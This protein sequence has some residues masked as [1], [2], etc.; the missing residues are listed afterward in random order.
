MMRGQRLGK[1]RLERRLGEGGFATVYRAYDTIEGV[2]VALKLPH[3]HLI[4]DASLEVFRK[5]V[6][7]NAQLDHPGVLP[8][9]Y[10]GFIDERFVVVYPLGIETLGDRLTRRVALRKALGWIEQMLEA[11]AFA[12]RRR[13]LHL[14]L[15]PD[16][17]I[18]FPGDRLR[19]ADFGLARISHRTVAASGSGTVGYLAPEQALGRP[20]PRS[21]VF[22]LGLILYRVLTGALPEWP[23]D[24]PPPRFER[25]REK[26][27]AETIAVL[28]RSLE[29]DHRRR[30]QDA[31]HMLAGF[32]RSRPRAGSVERRRK[33]LPK[34][35]P[36]A[37]SSSPRWRQVRYREFRRRFGKVL[38]TRHHCP[39]CEGPVSEAMRNCPWCG[40]ARTVH[41][42]ATPLP[43]RC[44]RCRR[45]LKLDWRFCPWC[46]GGAIGEVSSRAYSDRRYV[47]R[48]AHCRS[49]RLMP[50]MS[51]CPTCNRKVTRRWKI[52]GAGG[53]CPRCGWGVVRDHWR[54]CP[55]CARRLARRER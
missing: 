13:I 36:T 33:K 15:K 23:F 9:K 54:V 40:K 8:I 29:V 1:Y 28:R 21:D 35:R 39:G 5:E 20:S 34:R 47:G 52:E 14:D 22:S 26:I 37:A 18:L 10:A 7:V 43:R 25:L 45:G 55:W 31:G 3:P 48:C 6:R 44:P 50:F 53:T 2:R 27:P 32:R 11:V 4:D 17:F 49:P 24:W 30:F 38:D 46:F 19:L 51:Y 12:H 16:N 42:D 41:R